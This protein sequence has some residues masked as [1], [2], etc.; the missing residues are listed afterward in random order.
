M[1]TFLLVGLILIVLLIA[2]YTAVHNHSTYQKRSQ[3]AARRGWRYTPLNWTQLIKPEFKLAG[4][5]GSGTIWELQR[6]WR[7]GQLLLKWENHSASLPYGVVGILP[8]HI[9]TLPQTHP[10]KAYTL[11]ATISSWPDAY[12]LFTSHDQLATFFYTEKITKIMRQYPPWPEKGAIDQLFWMNNS[13]YIVCLYEKDW[14][15]LERMV[16]LGSTLVDTVKGE[17]GFQSN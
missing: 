5:T 2:G 1:N 7:D 6:F 11:S 3:K 14:D 4:R 16:T 15:I 12:Q 9:T 10:Y 17:K 13:L 8:I